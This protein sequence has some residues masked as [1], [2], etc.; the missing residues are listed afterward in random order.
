M[1]EVNFKGLFVLRETCSCD[2]LNES[3]YVMVEG[4]GGGGQSVKYRES[5]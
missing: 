1:D 5:F 4:G 3:F 2:K